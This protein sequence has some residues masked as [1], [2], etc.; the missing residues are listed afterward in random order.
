MLLL[1]EFTQRRS[2]RSPKRRSKSGLTHM[3]CVH[4]TSIAHTSSRNP[5][6]LSIEF[7]QLSIHELKQKQCK[8]PWT[9]FEWWILIHHVRWEHTTCEWER[10]RFSALRIDP[11]VNSNK[12]SIR[13]HELFSNDGSW[14]IMSD[15]NAQ[16]ESESTFASPLCGSTSAWTET[17]AA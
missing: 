3:F 1:I 17:K 15:E 6:I 8:I 9:F 4:V 10:F 12:S 13:F 7:T 16:H 14:Y 5:T 11:C 2:G